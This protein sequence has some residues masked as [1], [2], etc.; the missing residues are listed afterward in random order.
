MKTMAERPLSAEQLAHFDEQGYVA[1]EGVLSEAEVADLRRFFS[2]ELFAGKPSY[3][4]DASVPVLPEGRG[5]GVRHDVFARYH[6]LRPV[7]VNPKILGALRS[8]L[9]D[10]FVF[11]PEM[12][13]HD[14]RYGH[15]HKDTTP[16]ERDGLDFHKQPGFKMVQCA[17]YFQDNDEFGGGLDVVPRS[18]TE[19]DHTPPAPRVTFVDRVRGKLGYAKPGPPPP[20]EPDAVTIPSKAGDLVIF[21]VLTNHQ[22]TQP[23]VCGTHEIPAERRKFALFFICAVNNEHPR[24]YIDY[25]KGQYA[26][27][28][29]GHSYPDDLLE[30]AERNN[31]TLI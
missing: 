20:V 18:H 17:I 19:A 2:E 15:W 21:N 24:R 3:E 27:L 5:G 10:D 25:I 14:S 9:G 1:V 8:L 16:M 6:E 26:H 28:K 30:L 4:G 23:R 12:A 22:A 31:V 13:A 29:N 11:L 7:M